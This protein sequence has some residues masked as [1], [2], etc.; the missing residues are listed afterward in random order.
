[1]SPFPISIPQSTR[2]TVFCFSK[3]IQSFLWLSLLQLNVQI[4]VKHMH[5]HSQQKNWQWGK[6]DFSIQI[7][8]NSINNCLGTVGICF[9]FVTLWLRV[10][11]SMRLHSNWTTQCLGVVKLDRAHGKLPLTSCS[12]WV[13]TRA[14]KGAVG[15]WKEFALL[16]ISGNHD[17]V[18]MKTNLPFWKVHFCACLI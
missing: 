17:P 6:S 2:N 16:G 12:I 1:M 13:G 3:D 8:R 14:V 7:T 4:Y 10:S 18:V 5:T 9:N 15:L 11:V